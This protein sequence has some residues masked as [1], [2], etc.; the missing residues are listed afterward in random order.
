MTV[1]SGQ[2]AL[3]IGG[4]HGLGR[5]IAGALAGAGAAT[6]V[7]GR[8][9]DECA[10]AAKELAAEHDVPAAGLRGDVTDEGDVDAVVAGTLHRFGRIDVLVNSAGTN[11]RGPIEEVTRAGFEHSMAVNATGTW[12]ACRAV[13]TPMKAAGYG[14]IVNMASALGLVGAPDR[15]AY[16][17]AKGAVVQITKA[18]AVE[19]AGTGICVNA[20]APG[21]FE[22]RMN[23]AVAHDPQARLGSPMGRW[24]RPE[25]VQA[26]ALF[27]ASP[28]ASY[29]TGAILSVDGGA[30]AR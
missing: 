19:W 15:S 18:L 13:A 27:L 24:G 9:A 21:A 7:V 23:A 25:E 11:V 8:D 20:L 4:T 10:A 3:V 14:R 5:A 1:L 28:A 6:V 30:T 17:A 29:T 22:T 12:L 26:A 2:V 16:A